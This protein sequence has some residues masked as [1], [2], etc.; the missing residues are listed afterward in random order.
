MAGA[1]TLVRWTAL[2]GLMLLKPTVD[3]ENMV[4]CLSRV[5]LKYALLLYDIHKIHL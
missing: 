1:A 5:E 4:K 2:T 3:I